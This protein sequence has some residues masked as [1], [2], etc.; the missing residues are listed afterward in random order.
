MLTVSV[1]EDEP[2]ISTSSII[3]IVI[4]TNGCCSLPAYR[5]TNKQ[6]LTKT[7]TTMSNIIVRIGNN[8]STQNGRLYGPTPIVSCNYF[9]SMHNEGRPRPLG[10]RLKRITFSGG[11]Q[12][13]GAAVGPMLGIFCNK[14]RFWEPHI[15]QN[16]LNPLGSLRALPSPLS[17]FGPGMGKERQQSKG[18]N[19]TRRKRGQGVGSHLSS[20]SLGW[21]DGFDVRRSSIRYDTIEEFNVDSKAEYWA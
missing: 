13:F 3:I 18:G 17:G 8:N 7:S 1:A 11:F 10:T 2:S 15:H 16:A 5:N 9:Y 21:C 20:K 14:M 19:R 4:M 6:K 12:D